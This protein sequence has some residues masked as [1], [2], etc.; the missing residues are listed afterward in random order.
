MRAA[1]K[2]KKK[3]RIFFRDFR[4][5]VSLVVDGAKRSVEFSFQGLEKN[6]LHYTFRSRDLHALFDRQWHK[7]GVAVQST[8]VSLYVDCKLA[9]R[10]QTEDKADIERSGRTLVTTRVEDGR[11][12][13][14]RPP[15]PP[16]LVSFACFACLLLCLCFVRSRVGVCVCE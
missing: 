15:P 3:S 14:V 5:Q 2:Q 16:A 9:E 1:A 8:I 6:T 10:R 7:L 11:P 12:V 13:D 4:P